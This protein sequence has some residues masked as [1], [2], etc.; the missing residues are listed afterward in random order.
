M[1]K[2]L[3]LVAAA[4][5]ISLPVLAQAAAGDLD[6]SFGSDG[7]VLTDFGNSRA[8]VG[9]AVGIEPGGKI[10]V[11]GLSDDAGGNPD[12]TLVRYNRDGSLDPSFGL[13]GRVQT[14]FG[15]SSSDIAQAAAIEP[16]GK[17]VVAGYSN[18]VGT[19]DVALARYNRD[20]SL[21]PSF[22]SGG[23]VLTDLGGL[24]EASAVA[25]EADG[26][27][28]AVGVSTFRFAILRYNRDGS[29]DSSFGSGG[30]VLPD[31]GALQSGSNG[32]F[33]VAVE[34]NGKIVAAGS[35]ARDPAEGP[36][37]ALVRC[38]RDGSLDPSFGSGGK[39]LTH[40][41]S[42]GSGDVALAVAIQPNGK[43]V[44]AGF[45]ITSS[46]TLSSPFALARYNRDG[47][48]DP[49]FGSGGKV[50]THFGPASFDIPR[51][52]ALE[53]D[54]KIVAAGGSETGG[55]SDFALVRYA[56]DG[57]LD[58]SFGSGG[59]M[60]TDFGS[61]SFDSASDATIEPDGKIVAAGFSDAGGNLDFAL[62]RYLAR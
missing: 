12:F 9:Q 41:G 18:A 49:S 59:K 54:G 26:K 4:L 10:V 21:D 46:P 43:I 2:F 52:L 51:A 38:N 47:S 37:F 39:V 55:S 35:V 24:D 13:D 29:L 31:L 48:L 61:S 28:V 19:R 14:D 50:L 62:A 44:A 36:D 42:A 32:A 22:G 30:K 11:A 8:D 17:I 6:P 33:A 53:P 15:S 40:L 7:K 1:K 56:L 16:D 5:G 23:K 27:I 20:G 58:Q 25:V 3:L 60:L 34:P 45:S 57:S